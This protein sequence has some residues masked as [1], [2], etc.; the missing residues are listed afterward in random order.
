MRVHGISVGSFVLLACMAVGRVATAQQSTKAVEDE[1]IRIVKAQWAADKQKDATASMR[2]IA[3]DYTEFNGDYSTR[4]EGRDLAMRLAEAGNMDAGKTLVS[5][6]AN[7][8]VQ[9][10]GNVAILTYNYVGVAQNKDGSN[11]PVR[12]KSTRVYV[13]TGNDWMLVHANF[14]PDPLPSAR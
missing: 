14:A 5:E 11:T 1:I 13:K 7:P 6:M 10:Y 12:A 8:K 2:N 4:L 3:A 9:I